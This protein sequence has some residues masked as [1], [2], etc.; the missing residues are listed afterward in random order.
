MSDESQVEWG[1][2]SIVALAAIAVPFLRYSSLKA[3]YEQGIERGTSLHEAIF[4]KKKR[5]RN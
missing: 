2:F 3:Q 4:K 1:I 5:S